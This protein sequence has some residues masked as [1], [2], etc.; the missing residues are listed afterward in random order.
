[1]T[2][3]VLAVLLAAPVHVSHPQRSQAAVRAFKRTWSETHGGAPCPENCATWV[4]RDGRFR[5]YFRCGACQVDHICPLAAGG[6]DAPWNM[7]W[8][9][10]K[11]NRA[12]SADPAACI[13][14]P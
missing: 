10:A 6:A 5:L 12:K 14:A 2:A 8:L 1:M 11:E 9:D 13:P 3:L 7:Q 4:R